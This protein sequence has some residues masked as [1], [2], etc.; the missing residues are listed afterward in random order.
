MHKDYKQYLNNGKITTIEKDGCVYIFSSAD[1]DRFTIGML[2][3]IIRLSEHSDICLIVDTPSK[4]EQIASVLSKRW[5]MDYYYVG[6]IMFA[7]H[8]IKD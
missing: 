2:R 5:I 6:S 4:Q 8:Y 1:D 3:D 7:F